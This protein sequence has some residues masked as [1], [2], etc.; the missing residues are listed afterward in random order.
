M[1]LES[2]RV[3]R[4]SS[5]SLDIELQL[6]T[7]PNELQENY[8][9]LKNGGPAPAL[10]AIAAEATSYVDRVRTNLNVGNL[11]LQGL[12]E[13][14]RFRDELKPHITDADVEEALSSVLRLAKPSNAFIG[15]VLRAV[16]D[17]FEPQEGGGR[18][19]GRA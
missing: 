10:E 11:A 9:L 7:N 16:F 13:K 6:S 2:L 14:V 1:K 5:G 12:P 15:K 19:E 18:R 4:R 3:E 17:H 8:R